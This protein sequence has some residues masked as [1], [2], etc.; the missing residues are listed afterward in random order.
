MDC[1]RT[2]WK[3]N[4]EVFVF[5]FLCKLW[6]WFWGELIWASVICTY[7][8]LSPH[9][10]QN[11]SGC[12][13]HWTYPK[14]KV[15]KTLLRW[16]YVDVER[17]NLLFS[18]VHSELNFYRI[19]NLSIGKLTR[20]FGQWSLFTEKYINNENGRTFET[21]INNENGRTIEN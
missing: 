7:K 10:D 2:Y 6:N 18:L 21:W 8:T 16:I 3:V 17:Q 1:R 9:A 19:M 5:L 15:W 14:K 13:F 11:T 4:I 20:G 12:F